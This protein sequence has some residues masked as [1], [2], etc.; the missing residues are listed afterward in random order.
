MK[1]ARSLLS[2]MSASAVFFVCTGCAVHRMGAY[3]NAALRV[4]YEEEFKRRALDPIEGFWRSDNEFVEGVGVTYRT[5][6]SSND[7][8]PFA[9][10]TISVRPKRP[11]PYAPDFTRIGARFKPSNEDGVYHGQLL[12]VQGARHFWKDVTIRL[13]DPTTAETTVHTSEPVLGGATQRSY[14]VGPAQVLKSRLEVVARRRDDRFIGPTSSAGSG[15]LVTPS[16]VGTN[17][18]VVAEAKAIRCFVGDD[19]VDAKVVAADKDT[20]LALLK[21]AREAPADIKPFAL[22]DSSAVKQGSRVFAMGYQ[23]TAVVGTKLSVQEGT[24]SA[25]TGFEGRSSQF[26]IAMNVHPGSSGGP[27]LDER[28]CVLG[29]VTSKLGLGYMLQTGDIP[30]GMMFAAKSELIRSLAGAAGVTEQ[31]TFTC[32]VRPEMDLEKVTENYASGVVR[33][34]VAR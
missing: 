13:L 29:L 22:G 5:D 17:N 25:L 8:F 4:E 21:L 3:E 6:A 18:H 27:L 24:V 31:L 14:L 34:E 12:M 15:F 19:V 9:G 16:L 28:G 30:Q 32:P 11:L 1:A 2:V 26:Q 33:I 23:I 10:R 7:G 20:D